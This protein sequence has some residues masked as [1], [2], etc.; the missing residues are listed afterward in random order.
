LAKTRGRSGQ[1][2]KLFHDLRRTGV[3]N[4]IRAGA[5]ERI[6]IQISGDKTRAVLDRYNLHGAN[7][8]S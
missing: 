5:P 6:A 7:G 8:G 1:P 2:D 4:P 3:R